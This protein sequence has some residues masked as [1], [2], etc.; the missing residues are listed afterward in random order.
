MYLI[1]ENHLENFD[2][3]RFF[4][5]YF[6]KKEEEEKKHDF[7]L[8][9][10]KNLLE[11]HFFKA[12]LT[13]AKTSWQGV[14]YGGGDLNETKLCLKGNVDLETFTFFVEDTMDAILN[15]SATF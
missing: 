12:A 10:R 2:F 3:L 14:N 15:R 6:L 13:L 8:F 5:R 7:S 4:Q 1:E 11:K 9:S